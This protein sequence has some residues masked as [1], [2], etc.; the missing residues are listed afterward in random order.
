[1]ADVTFQADCSD[2]VDGHVRGHKT[3]VISDG[4]ETPTT[5]SL[6]MYTGTDGHVIGH[7][8]GVISDGPETPTTH[9]MG[10]F[11]GL[12]EMRLGRRTALGYPTFTTKGF[13]PTHFKDYSHQTVSWCFV[14]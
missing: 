2:E 8:T 13:N 5:Q 3:G 12:G 11:T 14:L 9:S 1:M 7:K 10:M 4:H 6:G